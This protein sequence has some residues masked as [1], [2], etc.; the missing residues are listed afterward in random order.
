MKSGI[1]S[2]KEKQRKNKKMKKS[3]LRYINPEVGMAKPLSMSRG[4]NRDH[5]QV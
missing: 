4:R 1:K 5:P 2:K 3:V